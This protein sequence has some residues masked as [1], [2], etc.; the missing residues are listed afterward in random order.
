MLSVPSKVSLPH[1]T[2]W[3]VGEEGKVVSSVM[4]AVGVDPRPG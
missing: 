4:R 2:T 3:G 1:L